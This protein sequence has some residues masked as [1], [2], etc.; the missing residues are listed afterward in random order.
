MR[1]RS[2][3][4]PTT[5]A[6]AS[7]GS[8]RWWRRIDVADVYRAD[9]ATLSRH[10]A[11]LPRAPD[12]AAA[13]RR[14]TRASMLDNAPLAQ[15]LARGR[16]LRPRSPRTSRAARSRALAHQRDELRHGPGGDVLR[17]RADAS[18]PMA[19]HAPSRRARPRSRVE[20]LMASTAIP[21]IF[22]AVRV[23]DDYYMDG[24]VR[25]IAPL[26][27]ALHLGARRILVIAVGQF[28]GQRPAPG[29]RTAPRLSVVRA[30]RGTCAVV[31]LPRQPRRRPRAA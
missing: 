24:S 2:R 19:A 16:R 25:Q 14:P 18:R 10:G 29:A 1:R 8:L 30:D 20:H 13:A 21:F 7:R 22:P 9:F 6:A 12:A 3:R 5:S 11:A 23:G 15:L 28:A 17:R 31:D 26:S 4:T 27:P